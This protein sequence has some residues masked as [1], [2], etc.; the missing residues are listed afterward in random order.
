MSLDIVCLL[1]KNL[2]GVCCF[3]LFL[4]ANCFPTLD[5]LFFHFYITYFLIFEN[6][7]SQIFRISTKYFKKFKIHIEYFEIL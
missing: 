7:K 4:K 2:E 5:G 3:G 6:F 1:E